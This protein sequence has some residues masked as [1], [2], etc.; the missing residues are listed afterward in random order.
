[1]RVPLPRS[2]LW[3]DTDSVPIL[4]PFQFLPP[5]LDAV[6][7]NDTA[8]LAGDDN[9]GVC[10]GFLYLKGGSAAAGWLLRRWAVQLGADRTNQAAL[11][12]AL[13]DALDSGVYDGSAG[14]FAHLV[15]P[16]RRF[17]SGKLFPRFK[18]E[19]AW[20]HANWREGR[21]AKRAFLQEHGLWDAG[22]RGVE[23]N[24]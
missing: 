15:L 1:L 4:D 2:V 17:P 9:A 22:A 14:P 10:G 23:C 8:R 21:D 13:R 5:A 7:T 11:N 18:T 16:Q 12:R 6:F 24:D 19:A 3:Q 20:C